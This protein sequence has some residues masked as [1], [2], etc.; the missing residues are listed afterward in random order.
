[1]ELL[2]DVGRLLVDIQHDQSAT[3][4]NLIISSLSSFENELKDRPTDEWLFGKDFGEVLK[5]KSAFENT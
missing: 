5:Q 2:S 4:R 3:R 1:M